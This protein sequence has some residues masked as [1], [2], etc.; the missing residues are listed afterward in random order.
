MRESSLGISLAP[1]CTTSALVSFAAVVVAGA[2]RELMIAGARSIAGPVQFENPS[3]MPR[4]RASGVVCAMRRSALGLH[5]VL[6]CTG[7]QVERSRRDDVCFAPCLC[8]EAGLNRRLERELE[9]G[10][11]VEFE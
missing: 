4:W 5:L 9:A 6:K 1:G 11:L 10:S 8:R 2:L 3:H 7:L